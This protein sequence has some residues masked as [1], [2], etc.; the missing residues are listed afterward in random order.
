MYAYQNG[1]EEDIP[2]EYIQGYGVPG[3]K[4]W[5][6]VTNRLVGLSVFMNR[7]PRH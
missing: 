3:Q 7:E 1:T 4:D 2:F 6:V 5:N